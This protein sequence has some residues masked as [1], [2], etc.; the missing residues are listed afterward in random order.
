M[1]AELQR[2]KADALERERMLTQEVAEAQA[3][4]NTLR[5]CVTPAKETTEP[6]V[7]TPQEVIRQTRE[8][9]GMAVAASRERVAAAR[10][11]ATTEGRCERDDKT[12]S[13]MIMMEEVTS[14]TKNCQSL[15][16]LIALAQPPLRPS[17]R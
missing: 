11:A 17:N 3:E 1:A 12:T 5:L 8:A 16:R 10:R 4:S 9:A 6:L 2:A 14:P 7:A 15:E 13:P